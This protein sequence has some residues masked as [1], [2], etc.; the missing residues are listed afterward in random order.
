MTEFQFL[1][2][3]WLL[4][5][6]PLGLLLTWHLRAGV[7][8]DPWKGIVDKRLLHH[9]RPATPRR[10]SMGVTSGL[11]AA[12][13]LAI[14]A[15]AGPVWDKVPPPHYRP[16]TPP[17]VIVLDLSRS[18]DATDLRP[19]RLA[20]ARSLVHSLLQRL[21]PRE[22]GLV[23]FAGGA[24]RVMP[25]T[26]DR[27]LIQTLLLQLD[28]GMMPVQGSTASA[29]LGL[30]QRLLQQAGSTQGEV[31]LLS[32]GVD[33]LAGDRAATL[34]AAG[35]RLLVLGIGTPQG[36]PI[37][38][39]EDDYLEVEGRPLLAPLDET[40]LE[41]VARRGDGH[42]LGWSGMTETLERILQD[43]ADPRMAGAETAAD[44]AAGEV[45]RE[46]GP[47]L[48]LFLLPIALLGFRRGLLGLVLLPLLLPPLPAEAGNW[49]DLW[50][51]PDQLARQRLQQGDY[52]AA[53]DLFR[54][55]LWRGTALYLAGDYAAAAATLA[56]SDRAIAHYN[57]GNALLRLGRTQDAIDAYS[58]ALRQDPDYT[59]ARYN[60]RLARRLLATSGT[61]PPPLSLPRQPGGKRAP[62]KPAAPPPD[63]PVD[64]PLVRSP[65]S[66]E[67]GNHPPRSEGGRVAGG[68]DRQDP[69]DPEKGASALGGGDAG[70][71][72][73]SGNRRMPADKPE[74]PRQP[75]PKRNGKRTAKTPQPG[76]A[77][78]SAGP[79]P[80]TRPPADAPAAQAKTA[81]AGP[82]TAPPQKTDKDAT[83][84]SPS[85]QR[86]APPAG[87]QET[88]V[89]PHPPS[90][91]CLPPAPA[92]WLQRVPDD[93][94]GLLQELFR[95]EHQRGQ[96][97]SRPGAPW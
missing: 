89:Q 21:P 13:L 72:K 41:A 84:S 95:R 46:R 79:K 15:L 16:S 43:L 38:A 1:R 42:Y 9:L 39:G 47:W 18:M 77:S 20:V 82:P 19:S 45:W 48:L 93:S 29:G 34:A 96:D 24:H 65:R 12:G 10:R 37:P 66:P 67:Q 35:F 75:T 51:N 74:P 64:Q 61:A 78:R 80:P 62:G 50:L 54:D 6:I 32:D 44:T 4:A 83:S 70:G 92:H 56:R 22:T 73:A 31:L 26:E 53:A 90:S 17:L 87:T 55:P 2:P 59:K 5:F 14:L 11:S 23:V 33:T 28:T 88:P 91:L 40:A 63:G 7:S 52:Q 69:P 30:A 36:G 71:Q 76:P 8:R 97:L 81:D 94:G 57:R 86:K 58:A 60:L 25:L 27:R 85:V 68:S 49:Q 3:L